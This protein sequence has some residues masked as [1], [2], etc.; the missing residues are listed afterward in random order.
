MW[1]EFSSPDRPLIYPYKGVDN[2]NFGKFPEWRDPWGRLVK[3]GENGANGLDPQVDLYQWAGGGT[4]TSGT[5]PSVLPFLLK[6]PP[7]GIYETPF[8]RETDAVPDYPS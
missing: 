2:P 8:G 5:G 4:V 7:K 3:G 6:N 1:W